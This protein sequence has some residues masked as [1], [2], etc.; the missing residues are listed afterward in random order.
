MSTRSFLL[1]IASGLSVAAVCVAGASVQFRQ[2]RKRAADIKGYLD[3]IPDLS[4]EQR[5]AVQEIR[6]VFLPKVEA[7]RQSMRSRRAELADLLFDETGERCKLDAV[8]EQIIGCQ[9]GLERQVIDHI[10]EEKTI[11]TPSQRQRFHD[12]IVA[13]FATGG[14]GIHDLHRKRP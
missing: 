1:G 3:L 12:I 4:P 8:V 7:L 14:V 11:L 2:S 6:E 5:A 10:L 9:A 13:Q